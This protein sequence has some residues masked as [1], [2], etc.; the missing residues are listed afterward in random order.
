MK[1]VAYKVDFRYD[2]G[3]TVARVV[4]LAYTSGLGP[5][6]RKD[7]WVRL[8]PLAPSPVCGA[9]SRDIASV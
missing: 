2:L 4:K 7:V 5:D 6:V 9:Q 3:D 1:R 8:P